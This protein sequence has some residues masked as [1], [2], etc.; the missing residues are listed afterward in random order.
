MSTEYTKVEPATRQAFYDTLLTF[1][2]Q[3]WERARHTRPSWWGSR[4]AASG[5]SGECHFPEGDDAMIPSLIA[6]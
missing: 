6:E 4:S 2:D 3:R 5:R 1:W